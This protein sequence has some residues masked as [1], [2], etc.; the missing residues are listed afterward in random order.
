MT[1]PIRLPKPGRVA[2][3]LL[4]V[5][6]T[7]ILLSLLGQVAKHVYGHTMLKGFVPAFYVDYE[8]NVPTWYSSLALGLAAALLLMIACV[9]WQRKDTFRRHWAALAGLLLLLSA[10]EIAMF[11]EYPIE[12]LRDTFQT[13]GVLYY[14][15]V[16]PGIAFVAL[17]GIALA[18][19]FWHLPRPTQAHF[20]L[21]AVV[22]VSGAIGVE[23]LSG[24]QADRHGEENLTYALIITVEESLEMLGVVIFI[25]GLVDYI[26]RELGGMSL[27]VGS[28]NS[29][30][31]S[32]AA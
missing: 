18:R 30:S 1:N 21:A 12:P 27:Q 23:M 26:H 8:S 15:W 7:L 6:G 24:V 22:F 31:L 13:G 14:P 2:S 17:V 9:H 5:V 29:G 28:S 10:D 19:F 16:L 20:L 25:R 11:H 4:M 32:Q 3:V